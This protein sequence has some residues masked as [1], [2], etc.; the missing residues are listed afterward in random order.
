M[1]KKGILE[2]SCALLALLMTTAGCSEQ[3]SDTAWFQEGPLM[4][5]AEGGT[6]VGLNGDVTLTIP[7]YA[8]SEPV[9][10][11]I[12]HMPRGGVQPGTAEASFTRPFIIEPYL[13]FMKPVR[14]TVKCSGCLN[15]GHN[16]S[17]GMEVFLAVWKNQ[18]DYRYQTGSCESGCCS[19]KTSQCINSC[20]STTGVITTRAF[21]FIE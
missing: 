1:A 7:E 13:E 6:V 2:W 8:L 19:D 20:I 18:S 11:E 3:E 10:I 9:A 17:E 15:N 12:L 21:G 14:L 5:G 4:I 16:V